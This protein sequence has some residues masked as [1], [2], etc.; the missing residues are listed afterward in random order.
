MVIEEMDRED[1]EM[2]RLRG[3][4]LSKRARW[5]SCG[6]GRADTRV[7]VLEK[8]DLSWFMKCRYLFIGAKN[9]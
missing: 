1:G 6:R 7:R 2:V 8:E 4:K 9:D 5:P 3:Y